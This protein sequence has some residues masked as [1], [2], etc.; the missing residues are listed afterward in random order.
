MDL[1]KIVSI[2]GMPG[3]YEIVAQRPDGLIVSSLQD[4][5]RSFVSAR[6]HNFTTLDNV[7]IY[8]NDD[9]TA[10]LGSI[11]EQMKQH[12]QP[13]TDSDEDTKSFFGL[14]V[15][16]HNTERVHLRDMKKMLRWYNIL[17]GAGALSKE[18]KSTSKQSKAK[19]KT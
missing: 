1:H 18:N 7:V 17:D 3:L 9:K 13:A 6:N 2:S 12:P 8:L 4:K 14:A 15:P 19:Q 5:S 16:D 11:F 10:D